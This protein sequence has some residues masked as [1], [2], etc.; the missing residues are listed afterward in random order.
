MKL[1]EFDYRL[2][3]ELI[4]QAPLN[5]RSA[6]RLMVVNKKIEHMHFH[7]ITAFFEKDDVVVLNNTKVIPARI[8]GRKLTGGKVE[9]LLTKKISA[10]KWCCLYRGKNI[11]EG[12][13]II[14]DEEIEGIISNK[15][16][17][18]ITINFNN[19]IDSLI[20]KFGE[21]PTPPYIKQKL[22]EKT[23]YNTVFAKTKGSIAAPTAG[24]HF[25]Q[26]LLEKIAAKGVKIVFIT[27]HVGIGT[28]LPVKEADISKHKMHSEYFELS[29]RTANAINSRRGKLFVCGTTTL[30]ALESSCDEKGKVFA[31]K[32]FTNIFIYPPYK[33]KL[34]F[35]AMIT[36][37]HL[38]K[39]T[40]LM[41]VSAIVGREKILEA[42]IVAIQQ[43]YR[44][45]S[46]GDAMLIIK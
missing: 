30:R 35:D 12:T 14:F 26:E 43:K 18:D 11:G 17:Y 1:S 44:F 46:F 20:E 40:L 4:A 13:R 39:S 19:K 22:S 3:Q 21:M 2:P 41:L 16:N 6:S 7:D 37:F 45:F 28:F 33:F 25:T 27:L 5:D 15:N 8:F 36:N 23:R 24:L 32:K 29:K 9:V 31:T 34:K 42:Y 10:K 38:P